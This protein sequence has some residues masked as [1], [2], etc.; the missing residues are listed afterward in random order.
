M[1]SEKRVYVEI[2]DAHIVPYLMPG[3]PLAKSRSKYSIG[4]KLN[5]APVCREKLVSVLTREIQ[6][7]FKMT[8]SDRCE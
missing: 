1:S 3:C 2:I 8:L 7:T 4:V 6:Q 5:P